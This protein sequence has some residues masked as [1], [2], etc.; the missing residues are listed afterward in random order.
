MMR[1]PV[2]LACALALAACG[3]PPANACVSL[4]TERAGGPVT[5]CRQDLDRAAC[6]Q[7]TRSS[8]FLEG[9]DCAAAGFPCFHDLWGAVL[10]QAR[11][12]SGACPAGTSAL[13]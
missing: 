12:A 7:E 5:S 9:R 11:D 8:S 6:A 4:Y 2:G 13:R 10:Y 1:A 3:S